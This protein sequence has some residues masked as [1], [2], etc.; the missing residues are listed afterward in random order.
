[1]E[2]L[3]NVHLSCF[4]LSYLVAF[5]VELYQ[6]A[7]GRTGIA[8][9]I[10][11][12]AVG[13]GL[14]AHTAY[15]FSRSAK[16]GLPPL[17]GSSHDWLLVLAWLMAVIYL[18]VLFMQE[19]VAIGV[20]VLPPLIGL[21]VMAMYVEDLATS[22]VREVATQRW[23]MLHAGTLVV[24][25][26]S[27][28]AATLC[29]AM[30][31]LQYQ[32][33]RGSKSKLHRL[34]LPSLERLTSLNRWLVISTVVMLTVGLLTGVILGA[35]KKAAGSSFQWL[36]PVVIGTSVVWL[37]MVGYLLWLLTQKEQSGRQVARL[38]LMAGAFLLFTIFGLMLLAG[39]V[40]GSSATAA[41]QVSFFI[42]K[43][44]GGNAES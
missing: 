25:M 32:K 8:R 10:L 1:M 16:S 30:Y 42:T 15:L 21:V 28:A 43:G 11:I 4:L 6:I 19:R 9:G 12:L 38:T 3:S 41:E 31:L 23:G 26:V 40:H 27:V 44:D 13:A 35:S 37:F 36:D 33:L 18:V 22:Q 2:L 7:R 29:G 20:F 24:G 5:G 14:V 17:V 39:G 34:Q